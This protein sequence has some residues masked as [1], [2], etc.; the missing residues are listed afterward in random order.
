MPSLLLPFPFP[1]LAVFLVHSSPSCFYCLAFVPPSRHLLPVPSFP[2]FMDVNV[3]PPSHIPVSSSLPFS[4]PSFFPP[5]LL[6]VFFSSVNFCL[7]L[8]LP[9]L[10]IIIILFHNFIPGKV[11][12]LYLVYKLSFIHYPLKS[13]WN[14]TPVFSLSGSRRWLRSPRSEDST[15]KWC[16]HSW[17][18]S[19][20][21]SNT[22]R[23]GTLK[24]WRS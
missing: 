24:L 9:L 5:Y 2:V 1:S 7:L 13:I 23:N 12:Y 4:V 3:P 10:S 18:P 6:Y 19:Q 14:L 8:S 11:L 21:Q 15:W 22:L 16:Q 17:M 20:C